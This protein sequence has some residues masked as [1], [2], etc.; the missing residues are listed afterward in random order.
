MVTLIKLFPGKY[1]IKHIKNKFQILFL[2]ENSNC[3]KC[4]PF[5]TNNFCLIEIIFRQ[6]CMLYNVINKFKENVINLINFLL[7]IIHTSH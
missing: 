3:L 5:F 7:Q 4:L 6:I 2:F 1:V